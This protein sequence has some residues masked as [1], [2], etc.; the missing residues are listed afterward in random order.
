MKESRNVKKL[1]CIFLAF[2]FYLN[3][4]SQIKPIIDTTSII[5]FLDWKLNNM[6][7]EN[8]IICNK[9]LPVTK[10]LFNC[11]P[12]LK[13]G[14]P[15]IPHYD[16]G[17]ICNYLNSIDIGFM[18]MQIDAI[19]IINITYFKSL[20]NKF[21]IVDCESVSGEEITYEFSIPLFSQD[22]KTV[23][24]Y[25][26]SHINNTGVNTYS[27]ELY[28]MDENGKWNYFHQLFRIEED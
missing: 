2:I 24:L 13:S 16:K 11:L 4:H 23:L 7:N 20:T 12:E 17:L 15:I 3:A 1:G 25:I 22:K 6:N 28:K 19:N 21:K 26:N 8:S 10:E 5:S 27:I 14:K 9:S 18:K